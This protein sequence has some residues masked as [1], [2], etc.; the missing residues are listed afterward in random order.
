[1][2]AGTAHRSVWEFGL[3]AQKQTIG[4]MCRGRCGVYVGNVWVGGSLTGRASGA[5]D[6][7]VITKSVIFLLRL[8][9]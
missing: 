3:P 4:G 1:M 6:S 5:R 8:G 7:G 9:M 2:L